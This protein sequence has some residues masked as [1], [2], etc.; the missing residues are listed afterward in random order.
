MD[1]RAVVEGSSEAEI[2]KGPGLCGYCVL[3]E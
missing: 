1:V 3:L 2:E